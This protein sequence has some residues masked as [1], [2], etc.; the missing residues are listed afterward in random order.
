MNDFYTRNTPS[1]EPDEEVSDSF[2]Q[3]PRPDAA[4]VA[5]L[6]ALRDGDNAAYKEVYL[7]WRKP[8][9]NLL[10]KLTG[11]SADAEDITQEVFI[12]LW[13]IHEK[14]DPAKDIRALLYVMARNAALALF[15]KRKVRKDYL[16]H[17]VFDDI[18]AT[19]TYDI[20]VEREKLLLAE[21]AVSRLEP[22]TQR[23]YEMSEKLLMTHDQIATK[24]GI[25]PQSV[26][27]Q[28]HIAN[29]AIR[30]A[31]NIF[32]LFFITNIK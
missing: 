28:L 8:I 1:S 29:K 32:I 4:S 22:Q 15:K 7:M 10:V 17:T 30:Q 19:T 18:D 11:S 27:N 21:L 9:H 25:S 16:D 14:V 24:L 12:K 2:N 20:V 5:R 3:I 13:E 26:S 31:I 23:I 6:E